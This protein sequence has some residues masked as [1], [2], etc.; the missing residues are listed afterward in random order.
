MKILLSV[1][2]SSIISSSNT[3]LSNTSLN[4][5]KLSQYRE[6]LKK[7]GSINWDKNRYSKIFKA[8]TDEPKAYRIYLPLVKKIEIPSAVKETLK[9]RGF[10]KI[11]YEKG[12]VLDKKRKKIFIEDIIKDGGIKK[13]YTMYRIKLEKQDGN[14][15]LLVCISRHPYDIAGMSTDRNWRSCMDLGGGKKHPKAGCRTRQIPMEI[16]GGILVAYLIK[17]NDKN[18][19][20]P[21]ARLAIRPYIHEKDKKSMIFVVSDRLFGVKNKKFQ[22]IVHNWV[23]SV[24]ERFFNKKGTYRLAKHLYLDVRNHETGIKVVK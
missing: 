10:I 6:Q 4:A 24:N 19:N 16:K 1:I 5:I 18:I 14:N 22:E 11:N 8:Y 15:N 13:K 12:F 20:N 9:E 17:K 2:S 23:D 21:L 3:T 7:A